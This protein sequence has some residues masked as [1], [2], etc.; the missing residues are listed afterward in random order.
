[1]DR[2][3]FKKESQKSLSGPA[4]VVLLQTLVEAANSD[5]FPSMPSV[6]NSFIESSRKDARE[7]GVLKYKENLAELLQVN[8]VFRIAFY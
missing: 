1:L 7:Y 2:I 6:W 5:K 8:E 4:F 3:D